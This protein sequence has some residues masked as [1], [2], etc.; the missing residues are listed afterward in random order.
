MRSHP[1]LM[2]LLGCS[3]EALTLGSTWSEGVR[4]ELSVGIGD[5]GGSRELQQQE[6]NSHRAQDY[7]IAPLFDTVALAITAQ[8]KSN[9]PTNRSLGF[10]G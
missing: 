2:N 7:K 5:V 4:R 8:A 1:H 6:L 9:L 3:Q 10:Q